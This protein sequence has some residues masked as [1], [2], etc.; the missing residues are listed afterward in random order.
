M[1]PPMAKW[2]NGLGNQAGRLILAFGTPL[3]PREAPKGA[4]EEQRT[5]LAKQS[6]AGVAQ[7]IVFDWSVASVLGSRR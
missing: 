5:V 1:S 3:G 6:S 4:P 7:L 2:A